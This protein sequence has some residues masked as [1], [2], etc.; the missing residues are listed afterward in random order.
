MSASILILGESGSGK[1]AS[2]R[3][4]NP[5]ET[6]I[7][8]VIDKPFPFKNKY[9]KWTKDKETEEVSGNVYVT[10]DHEILTKLISFVNNKRPEIT[11]FVID[12]FQYIMANE[13]MRKAH[14]KGFS[15]FT[16]I[17]QHSFK[18]I[19][20]TQACRSD[21]TFFFLTHSF[22]DDNGVSKAKTIGK[23]L[24][25][26]VTI[27]GRFTVVFHT[28]VLE[29]KYMFMTQNDGKH[30]AKSPIDMFDD[31]LIPNDLQ[32]VKDKMHQ[33]YDADINQ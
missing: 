15:K 6:F 4:L 19:D 26:T 8:S 32:Y 2:L 29:R 20:A 12:D 33:Y 23:L 27:E 11:N 18:I 13:F 28:Q 10:D 9:K 5:D 30:I 7:V 14:E 17:A 1:S 3:N 25:N 21:L 22:V 31:M 24:D 16:E